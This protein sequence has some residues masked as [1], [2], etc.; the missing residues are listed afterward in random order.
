[1]K[2]YLLTAAVMLS[3]TLSQA[4]QTTIDDGLRYSIEDIMGT[5]RF[6]AMSG[7]FG[8]VGGDLSSIN[9]NPAGSAIFSHNSATGSL[10]NYNTKNNASYFG[11]NASDNKSTLNINQVGAVFIFKDKN[12][13][14]EWKKIALGLNY[15][16]TRNLDSNIF[17]RGTNPSSSISNYFLNFANTGNNGNAIPAELVQLQTGESI[18]DLYSYLASLPNG[19]YPGINGFA[20]QQA[21]LGYQAFLYD[22]NDG[23]G[24]TPNTPPFYQSNVPGGSFYQENQ[25]SSTGYNG[26]LTGNFSAEYNEKL[27][28]GLNLNAHFTDYKKN[29]I[30]YERNANNPALGV[31]QIQFENQ[32]YTYG[33][34]FSFNLGAILKLTSEFRVG[35]AYQSPTWYRLNDELT[36]G[37]MAVS[38]DGTNTYTDSVY[39][40]V[41]NVYAPYNV[42][43]PGKFTGSLAY[44]FGKNGLISFDYGI[45]DY[46]QTKFKPQNDAV[47]RNLNTAMSNVLTTANEYRIGGEYKIKKVSLRAGYRYEQSPYKDRKTVGNLTG[48]SG[49]LG[50]NFGGSRFDIAYSFAK[51]DMSVPFVS[52]GMND[53]ARI[54]A[55]SNNIIVSYTID[56]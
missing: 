19:S 54:N 29:S 27:Y 21:F 8:A 28:I 20:A 35:A 22:Y 32:L 23:T 16:I 36:Q 1:M 5:A 4:Q 46:S 51:R 26:K 44:I 43:T 24:T 34:G 10:V 38:Q 13:K 55:K 33:G 39:P 49:G 52:S 42:Q 30:V 17:A 9:I 48:Y 14:S 3:I 6:R 18:T 50:Y 31:Q 7:A 45:K 37:L 40:Q 25:I 15:E 41:T 12:P 56:F 47:F 53:M 2:R 11:T